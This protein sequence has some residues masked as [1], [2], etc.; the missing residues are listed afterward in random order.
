MCSDTAVNRE[1]EGLTEP[2]TVPK[3]SEVAWEDDSSLHWNIRL[4]KE[5]KV[6]GFVSVLKEALV[7]GLQPQ[8]RQ[9]ILVVPP[10][11]YDMELGAE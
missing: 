9:F 8:D 2:D 7:T 11:P 1:S 10:Q 5:A 3:E 4:T 6:G